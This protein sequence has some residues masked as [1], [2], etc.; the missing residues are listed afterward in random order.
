MK[1]TR[2]KYKGTPP[3]TVTMNSTGAKTLQRNRVAIAEF[4]FEVRQLTT[5]PRSARSPLALDLSSSSL[6][7][8]FYHPPAI[9][10]LFEARRIDG[11]DVEVIV[12]FAASAAA[13]I[14]AGE[15]AHSDPAH[16]FR[17]HHELALVKEGGHR[18]AVRKMHRSS[19]EPIGHRTAEARP[20]KTADAELWRPEN[21]RVAPVAFRL[22]QIDFLFRLVDP[23]IDVSHAGP[24][25]IF[26]ARLLQRIHSLQPQLFELR[27]RSRP[28]HLEQ[29]VG[30]FDCLRLIL[31]VG[32]DFQPRFFRAVAPDAGNEP[33]DSADDRADRSADR[34]SGESASSSSAQPAEDSAF[35]PARSQQRDA[36]HAQHRSADGPRAVRENFSEQIP[37]RPAHAA[38]PAART[39]ARRQRSP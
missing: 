27:P 19:R 34:K 20:N 16:G 21:H 1:T 31:D 7:H 10:E 35:S 17:P 5:C 28:V 23:M 39:G 24:R 11:V 13:R 12:N 29:V 36:R 33:C 4:P 32:F 9:E 30:V 37:E 26:H 38:N 8:N 22:R 14:H 25:N 3:T 2:H 18:A 15:I 6:T